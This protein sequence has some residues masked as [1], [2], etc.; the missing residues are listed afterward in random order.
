MKK[1]VIAFLL[2]LLITMPSFAG[3]AVNST[4]TPWQQLYSWVLQHIQPI[5]INQH[6]YKSSA[7]PLQQAGTKQQDCSAGTYLDQNDE[8]FTAMSEDREIVCDFMQEFAMDSDGH[9]QMTR[10]YFDGLESHC[11]K[12]PL[13]R[14]N[15]RAG[16]PFTLTES[17]IAL[18]YHKKYP[19]NSKDRYP[20]D[21]TI[22]KARFKQF[23]LNDHPTFFCD[24]RGKTYSLFPYIIKQ[25]DSSVMDTIYKIVN[26]YPDI[27][28]SEVIEPITG[29]TLD[30]YFR[31]KELDAKSNNSKHTEYALRCVRQMLR[32]KYKETD[33][34]GYFRRNEIKDMCLY[35]NTYADHVKKAARR[36]N[37]LYHG[38]IT[39]LDF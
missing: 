27:N 38:D 16:S 15:F 7:M 35:F 17:M 39:S 10:E 5:A 32:N 29:K 23:L 21:A 22:V 18:L 13:Q 11:Y 34:N 4:R 31:E 2:S 19:E 8:I 20:A 33:G 25:S 6:A 1:Q 12:D 3:T 37:K 24:K 36:K 26:N 9:D 28:F 30:Q 14:K